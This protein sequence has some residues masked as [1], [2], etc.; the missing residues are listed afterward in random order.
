MEN[1]QL[2]VP[3]P[4]ANQILIGNAALHHAQDECFIPANLKRVKLVVVDCD[5]RIRKL[6]QL[7]V[8]VAAFHR[9]LEQT[10]GLFHLRFQLVLVA[11]REIRPAPVIPIEIPQQHGGKLLFP[12]RNQI[13]AVVPFHQLP[14][15]PHVR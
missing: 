14:G 8:P 3:A 12:I 11:D 5:L 9:F 10:D 7:R 2:V 1:N 4:A 6:F 13:A 15:H